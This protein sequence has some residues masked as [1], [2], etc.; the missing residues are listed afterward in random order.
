MRAVKDS[1]PTPLAKRRDGTEK[2]TGC[3]RWT[4]AVGDHLALPIWPVSLV[5]PVSHVPRQGT[6]RAGRTAWP[7]SYGREGQ[8]QATT[9]VL[10][11]SFATV[12]LTGKL[13]PL[14][15]R[16]ASQQSSS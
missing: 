5:L 10:P 2:E 3:P 8:G 1:P 15:W 16:G 12:S 6:M 11:R 4:R 13:T 7:L 9:P 14:L